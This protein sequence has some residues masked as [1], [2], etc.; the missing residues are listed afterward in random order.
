M[1]TFLD[2]QRQRQALRDDD[3]DVESVFDVE[4]RPFQIDP[5]TKITG[6]TV[7]DYCRRRWGGSGWTNHLKQEG[8]KNDTGANFNNWKYWPH[9][10][11][12]H[13][14]VQFCSS[15]LDSS[16]SFSPYCTSDRINQLLFEAEY[17]RGENISLVD[18]L[19]RIGQDAGVPTSKL[20]ELRQYLEKDE[21]KSKV[22]S[23]I[24]NGR[25]RYGISG[26][27]FFIV[28]TAGSEQQQQQQKPYA[29]SGAQSTETLLEIFNELSD[30]GGPN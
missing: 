15:S 10:S 25:K 2:R 29:F 1:D 27:P 9:T 8:R 6:E 19:V 5:G 18:V 12:A 16:S 3:D 23:D 17:E 24:R 11:K 20:D 28:T 7:D 13:Q 4:W 22:E 14:L 26:V 30:D 21:G